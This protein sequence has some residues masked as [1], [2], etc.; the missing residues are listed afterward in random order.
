MRHCEKSH[1]SPSAKA[2]KGDNASQ[3]LLK[4]QLTVTGGVATLRHD[5]HRRC[6]EGAVRVTPATHGSGADQVATT[7][8]EPDMDVRS[9]TASVPSPLHA[10][11]PWRGAF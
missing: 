3:K 2:R 11:P 9:G 10:I 1:I 4:A 5:S 8:G 7:E 6:L